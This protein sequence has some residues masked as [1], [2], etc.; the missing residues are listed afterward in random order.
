MLGTFFQQTATYLLEHDDA[1]AEE[2]ET[3]QKGYEHRRG[4]ERWE[5][6]DH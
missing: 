5:S 1:T 2:L 6:P 4:K 3:D